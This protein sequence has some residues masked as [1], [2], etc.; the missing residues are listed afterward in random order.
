MLKT[1]IENEIQSPDG[2]TDGKGFIKVEGNTISFTIQEGPIKE[3]G[4]NGCQIDDVIQTVRD[5][6]AVASRK[7]PCLENYMC[8]GK[9]DEA[10]LWL[11][12]R[13]LD[14]E[15]RGVEGLNKH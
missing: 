5:M 7:F 3:V 10:M 2:R 6:I 8:L 1:F 15:K 13:K 4:V 11:Y 9:L 14:R 12:K